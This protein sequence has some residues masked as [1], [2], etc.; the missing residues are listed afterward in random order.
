MRHL[1][2]FLP[3]LL[4]LAFPVLYTAGHCSSEAG[5]VSG[6][7]LLFLGMSASFFRRFLLGGKEEK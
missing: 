3:V 5:A 6:L 4:L 2:T 1:I 7:V